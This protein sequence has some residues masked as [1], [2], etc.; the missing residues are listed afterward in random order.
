MRGWFSLTG[1]ESQPKCLISTICGNK[2]ELLREAA[3]D[4]IAQCDIVKAFH[5]MYSACAGP[6]RA[7]HGYDLHSQKAAASLVESLASNTLT[8]LASQ[9]E[10]FNEPWLRSLPCYFFKLGDIGCFQRKGNP[11]DRRLC[12]GELCVDL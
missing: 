11:K 12:G 7:Q 9:F 1:I 5:Y 6:V 3:S 4:A 8:V 10:A 2:S